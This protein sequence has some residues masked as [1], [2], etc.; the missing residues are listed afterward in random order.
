MAAILQRDLFGWNSVK[1]MPDL[2]RFRMVRDALDD[3][4]L[5][6]ELER[7]RGRGRN[8]YPVRPMWNAVVLFPLTGHKTWKAYVRE[9]GRNRDLMAVCG[10]PVGSKVPAASA[11]SRF[12]KT[13]KRLQVC[14]DDLIHDA[15]EGLGELLPDFGEHLGVDS[16]AVN[17]SARKRS[18]E[19]REDGQ[20]DERGEHDAENSKKVSAADGKQV[21]YSWFGF[22]NHL[23]CDTKYQLPLLPLVAG[24]TSSD[25]THFAPLLE[26]YVSRHPELARRIRECS[27]DMAYD[28]AENI[29]LVRR[30]TDG[31]GGLF[32]PTRKT[33]KNPDFEVTDTTG[34]ELKLKLIGTPG[35]EDI[36]YDEDGQLYCCAE[37]ASERWVHSPMVFKGYEA[38]RQTVK[39]VCHAAHYGIRCPGRQQCDKGCGRTVRVRLHFDPR[40]FVPTPRHTAKFARGYRRRTAVERIN[41]LFDALFDIKDMKVRGL[42]NARFRVSLMVLTVL[43]MARARIANNQ[44][45]KMTSIVAA[46]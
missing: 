7:L 4:A 1:R 40:V 41:G 35:N 29:L 21:E 19:R 26:Q 5:V 14:V 36:C 43:T 6:R 17:S 27:A 25:A 37:T 44:K 18:D 24:G 34:K 12:L 13:V 8:D 31:R 22:K 3:E 9:L 32:C 2:E 28:S 23:L 16:Q 33:W 30:L 45:E 46:A 38:S 20:P 39:Y 11:V 42:A 15:I 10:F